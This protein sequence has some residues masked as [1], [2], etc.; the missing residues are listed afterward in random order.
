MKLDNYPFKGWDWRELCE[1]W[2]IYVPDDFYE[3]DPKNEWGFHPTC[4][5]RDPIKWFIK[6]AIKNEMFGGKK[7][8]P[9]MKCAKDVRIFLRLLGD[10]EQSNTFSTPMWRGMAEITDDYTLMCHTID[11]IGAMWD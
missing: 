9:L 1:A 11:N 3:P 10:E 6:G 8:R 2:D 4:S 5:E 7:S